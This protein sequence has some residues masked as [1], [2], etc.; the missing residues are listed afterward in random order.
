[1]VSSTTTTTLRLGRA[2]GRA[3]GAGSGA[4]TGVSL[5]RDGWH[6]VVAGRIRCRRAGLVAAVGR[7]C[8]SVGALPGRFPVTVRHSAGVRAAPRLPLGAS[9]GP[10][11]QR[12]RGR[13]VGRPRAGPARGFLQVQAGSWRRSASGHARRGRRGSRC[14]VRAA[15]GRLRAELSASRRSVLRRLPGVASWHWTS[16]QRGGPRCR[17]IIRPWPSR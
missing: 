12:H 10:R 17:L 14:G 7:S 13:L 5:G 15:G 6:G 11:A 3:G 16:R 9:S 4:G 2:A 1:M 8:R